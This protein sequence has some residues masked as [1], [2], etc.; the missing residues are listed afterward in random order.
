MNCLVKLGIIS[1]GLG[2]IT[3]YV[4]K[5][6]NTDNDDESEPNSIHGLLLQLIEDV[7]L[8]RN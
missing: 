8:L 6:P 1:I 7:R 2:A 5:D 3:Y 4:L